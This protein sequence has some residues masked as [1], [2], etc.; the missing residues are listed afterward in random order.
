MLSYQESFIPEKIV[1]EEMNYRDNHQAFPRRAKSST[2]SVFLSPIQLE[3]RKLLGQRVSDQTIATLVL[4]ALFDIRSSESIFQ[5]CQRFKL[6]SWTNKIAGWSVDTPKFKIIRDYLLVA[7]IPSLLE[8]ASS[9]LAFFAKRIK[10]IGPVRATAKRYYRHENLVLGEVDAQ[11]KNLAMFLNNLQESERK[12]FSEW[13]KTNFKFS[14]E[15]SPVGDHISLKIKE[16]CN[17]S[18]VNLTDTGFGFSQLLPILTQIWHSIYSESEARK[19]LLILAIEQPELHLHPKLQ[20][21]LV[22]AIIRSIE[23]A[24]DRDLELKFILETHSSIFINRFGHYIAEK[25]LDRSTVNVVLFENSKT[26]DS[27]SV[28]ATSYDDKGF[29]ER[30]PIGFLEPDFI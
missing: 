21:F 24:N 30:W 16:E 17:P 29:L 20:G 9:Y 2:R 7:N 28:T 14:V 13:T 18:E 26:V 8:F 3:I 6:K 23:I 11:G 1:I 25:K 10:Y 12:S 15:T 27:A 5:A 22:D 19:K 4:D